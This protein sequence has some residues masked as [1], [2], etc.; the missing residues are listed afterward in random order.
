M[1]KQQILIVD[2]E[3][4]NRLILDGMF[5]DEEYSKIE[6]ANGKEAI[7]HIENT[8]NIALIL[9]DIIMPVM[10]GF[11]VLEYMRENDL[12]DTIPVILIT[13][14]TIGDSEDKAYSYGVADVIHKPFY[15]YIVKKR[16]NN[17]IKLYQNKYNMEVRLKEQEK[18]ILAQQKEINDNNEF[19]IDA[20]SSVIES[21]NAETGDHTK[22]IKSL[23]RIM[24]NCLMEMFPK[25]GLTDSQVNLITRASVLHDI[26]KIG[27]PDAILLKP[28]RLTNEEFEI[29]KTHTTIG[30]EILQKFYRNQTSEF[31]R[32][33]YEICR[34]HHERWDGRGYPD[35]L[36]GDEIPIS[37]Q[38]VAITD[39]YDAL[40]SPRV[41]KSSF[42]ADEAYNMIVNGECGQ[43]PPDILECFKFAKEKFSNIVELNEM[44][45]FS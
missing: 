31:D 9:L 23:T 45:D 8:H 28:G 6:A 24:L 3:E 32:Y 19:V 44:Y 11:K 7:Y 1:N 16:C 41:Y 20:L 26:G 40:I 12:L 18:A 42:T 33:C 25:Y 39:V 4:I 5:D 17:I 15:P 29:M 35:H 22:R 10:D 30:G 38:V 37:A 2:D 14:E 43:F 21:R 27:I 36:A 13:S 34:H